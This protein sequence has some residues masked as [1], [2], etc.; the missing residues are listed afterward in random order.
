MPGTVTIPGF[1]P[2]GATPQGSIAA[3]AANAGTQVGGAGT[4]D[5]SL[6]PNGPTASGT[7]QPD[8]IG[9][10]GIVAALGQPWLNGTVGGMTLA[11]VGVFALV[12]AG[13]ITAEVALPILFALLGA[14]LIL[15][16][17]TK[18]AGAAENAVRQLIQKVTG[19]GANSFAGLLADGVIVVTVLGVVY[20]I[21]RKKSTGQVVVIRETA[22]SVRR[23][24]VRRRRMK[25]VRPL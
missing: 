11:G 4:P 20:L 23:N 16:G 24:P 3:S 2:D 22:P 14:E 9:S 8:Q 18:V 6:Q 1:T 5:D 21:Y 13:L 19:G 12:L 15:G 7:N 10:Q 17:V 25:R